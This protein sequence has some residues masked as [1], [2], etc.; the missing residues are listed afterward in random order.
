MSTNLS[1]ICFFSPSLSFVFSFSKS[2]V[3]LDVILKFVCQ[4]FFFENINKEKISTRKMV[5]GVLTADWVR[6]NECMRRAYCF[7]CHITDIS[8]AFNGLATHTHLC[9]VEYICGCTHMYVSKC[10]F[11]Y[12]FL[13]CDTLLSSSSDD[14][15]DDSSPIWIGRLIASIYLNTVHDT[16]REHEMTVYDF[17]VAG[18]RV[19]AFACCLFDLFIAHTRAHRMQF[20]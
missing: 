15:T 18:L 8:L 6:I 16:A 19:A 13:W 10:D 4:F 12:P 5:I 3:S 14:F 17:L 9:I 20:I 11:W 7:K 1:K 2:E